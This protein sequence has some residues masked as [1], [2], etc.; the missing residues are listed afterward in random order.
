MM[1]VRRGLARQEHKVKCADADRCL[2]SIRPDAPSGDAFFSA[3]VPIP[4]FVQK[5]ARYRQDRARFP[6]VVF[7]LRHTALA[8]PHLRHAV[9]TP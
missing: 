6:D 5:K 2:A 3:S 8:G 9:L 4:V 7:A 1:L